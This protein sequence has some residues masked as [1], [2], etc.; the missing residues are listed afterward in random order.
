VTAF[1]A[2]S[3]EDEAFARA[4]LAFYASTPSYRAVMAH[5]G[6]A[7]VAEQLSAHSARGE[8]AEMP[9]LLTNEMLHEFCLCVDGA[10]L[11]EALQE[12]YAGIA[13]RLTLYSPFLPGERGEYWKSL[14]SSI[15]GP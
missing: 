8:W 6:W 11:A 10:D 2:T 1:V 5:Y 14:A 9:G 12:R 4:Q 7:D 15:N 13:D 3:D